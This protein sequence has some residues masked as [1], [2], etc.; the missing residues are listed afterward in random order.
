[1][2]AAIHRRLN[3]R[4]GEAFGHDLGLVG[5][6]TGEGEVGKA[7]QGYLFRM[8]GAGNDGD[9]LGRYVVLLREVFRHDEVFVRYDA[10]DSRDDELVLDFCLQLLQVRLQVGGR[11]DEYQRV[12]FLHDV[13]DVGTEVDA[14]DVEL[15]AG[16]VRGVVPQA[17]EVGDAV[18]AAHIPV[19]GLGFREDNLG[20]GCCPTASAH[21]GYLS[22]E[23]HFSIFSIQACTSATLGLA[24]SNLYF[25][26]RP[27]MSM[28]SFCGL[29][30]FM[31]LTRL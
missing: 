17:F 15:H 24:N 9:V 23:F 18:V 27:Q 3:V 5:V 8:A 21:H 29:T 1:M 26:L 7:L 2:P 11:G 6:R 16:Q 10:L 12:R 13:V 20:D 22:R 25:L 30:S 28:W 4:A 14:L 31:S 19:D